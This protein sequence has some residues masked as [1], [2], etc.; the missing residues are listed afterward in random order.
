MQNF[1][2]TSSIG[3][4]NI[5]I[6]L[7]KREE[8]SLRIVLALPNASIAGLASI[9]WSSKEPWIHRETEVIG[10]TQMA[11]EAHINSLKSRYSQKH[12]FIEHNEACYH[13]DS[14][15]LEIKINEILLYTPYS[16]FHIF[17]QSSDDGKVLDHP[18]RVDSFPCTWLTTDRMK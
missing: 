7:T 2:L 16:F 4:Q 5:F 13:V 3:C 18:L 15:M 10:C 1:L 14:K 8:L 17:S 6:T 12:R 11:G 9:I